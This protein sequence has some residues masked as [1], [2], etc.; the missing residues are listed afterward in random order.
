MFCIYNHS[1]QRCHHK[2]QKTRVSSW[3]ILRWSA[4][5]VGLWECPASSRV[6]PVVCSPTVKSGNGL[7]VKLESVS[8]VCAL[9]FVNVQRSDCNWCVFWRS[10]A[11]ST[12]TPRV[13][14][15]MEADCLG[16][17]ERGGCMEVWVTAPWFIKRCRENRHKDRERGVNCGG[18]VT[19][20]VASQCRRQEERELCVADCLTETQA[21]GWWHFMVTTCN[22]TNFSWWKSYFS[23]SEQHRIVVVVTAIQRMTHFCVFFNSSRKLKLGL[24]LHTLFLHQW[25][26]YLAK[27]RICSIMHLWCINFAQLNLR[28]RITRERMSFEAQLL[29]VSRTRWEIAVNCRHLVVLKNTHDSTFPEIEPDSVLVRNL[30]FLRD[31]VS[32]MTTS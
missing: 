26:I 20:S 29:N 14:N 31:R 12:A 15:T 22:S 18:R 9:S 28:P 7:R 2:S 27:S 24:V 16:L 8:F 10:A 11:L 23:S 6:F 30:I 32:V 21:A 3:M 25:V 5:C 4:S 17:K 1:S 13:C 19:A